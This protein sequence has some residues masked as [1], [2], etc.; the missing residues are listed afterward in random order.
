MKT[1]DSGARAT[2]VPFIMMVSKYIPQRAMP[3]YAP[4]QARRRRG[5][6]RLARED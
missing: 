2:E 5:D 1:A 6:L 3:E 4:L